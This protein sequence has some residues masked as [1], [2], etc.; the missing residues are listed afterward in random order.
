[1]KDIIEARFFRVLKREGIKQHLLT[2]SQIVKSLQYV[3]TMLINLHPIFTST[4]IAT[5]K[6]FPGCAERLE[7]RTPGRNDHTICQ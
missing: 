1:M 4:E 5:R 7:N 2:K 6:S 3:P